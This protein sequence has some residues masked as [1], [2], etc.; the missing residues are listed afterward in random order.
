Q[1]FTGSHRYVLDYLIEEVLEQQPEPV[2][3]F[4]LKTAVLDRLTAPLCNALTKQNDGQATLEMLEH[5]DLF[6]VPLDEERRWYR[7]HH[8]FAD[9]LR[10]QLWQKH[11]EWRAMLHR[12]ASDWYAQ[13]NSLADAIRHALAAEDFT[14]VADLAELA[15]P[16][17]QLDHRSLIWLGWVKKLPA[18]L[19][20]KRPVLCVALA[21]AL[22]NAGQLEAAAARLVDA[23]RCLTSAT[24]D[25]GQPENATAEM[26]YVDEAQFQA[27]PATLATA[28]AYH[29]QAIGDFAGT[30]RYVEQTL[31]LLPADD[32]Y[33]RAAITGFMGLAHWANGNLETAYQ[34]FVEGLSQNDNDLIK[35]TFILAEMQMALGNLRQAEAVCERG[36][37]L[38]KAHDPSPP[39]GTEDVYAGISLV[40]REQGKL[41]T[42]VTDLQTCH[43]LGEK[44]K[45]PDWRHRWCLAQS[46]LELSLG[47]L[48]RA[49]ELLDEASRVYVRTPV[50]LVRPIAAMKA[51]V[52]LKQGRLDEA[53]AWAQEHDISAK[54]DLSYLREF[55]HLIFARL[56]M[57]RYQRDQ[58]DDD[59]QQ[60]VDLL[61]RLL[62]AAEAH[63]RMG[64][65][66]EI[67]IVQA[68]ALVAQNKLPR[69]LESLQRALA[70]AE[71]EGYFQC[72][73]DEGP[74]LAR[75]LYAALAQDI[76]PDYVR[77][78]LAA[79]PSSEP[80]QTVQPQSE[81]PE[82]DWIEPLSERE[83]E[84]LQLVADGLTNQQIAAQLFLALNTIKAHTR[85]IYS[86]LGV[87]SRIRA[88]ARA[89]D[90]GVLTST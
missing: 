20:G 60:A 39:L 34:I 79:F 44:V 43:Q 40:H 36:L 22:L 65:A 37:Q 19:V 88:V 17:W 74:S 9:L 66:I 58:S 3:T 77:R 7:Y 15:W 72:F 12:R 16:N 28:R 80:E 76:V 8:L 4:L 13:Q 11:P 31:A 73:V 48:E 46:Q 53:E 86:K 83:L 30:V 49:L 25:L 42:A 62:Q 52:W 63:Q 55:E 5:A 18:A 1:S 6:I 57:A 2:Q 27:L 35:G 75:L 89:R 23:E 69:A 59:L 41:K 78:L 87:N 24:N 38:A 29:A 84:V 51:R 32:L 64:S 56:L 26:V 47:N 45:L 10:Q 54:N 70:L 21:Q 68:L 82:L 71:P 14:R 81:N 61:A 33:N 90:L 85:N 50:P 67:L